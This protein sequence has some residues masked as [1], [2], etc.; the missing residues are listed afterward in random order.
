MSSYS[1]ETNMPAENQELEDVY[2]IEKVGTC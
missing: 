2:P 1:P